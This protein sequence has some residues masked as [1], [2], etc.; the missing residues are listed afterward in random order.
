MPHPDTDALVER[1][2]SNEQDRKALYR[3][4]ARFFGGSL[5]RQRAGLDAHHLLG[6]VI[7]RVLKDGRLH[8]HPNPKAYLMRAITNAGIDAKRRDER[9]RRKVPQ[10]VDRTQEALLDHEIATI[11]RLAAASVL[12]DAIPRLPDRAKRVAR[13]K[14]DYPDL[15]IN[16]LATLLD[17]SRDTVRRAYKDMYADES[18]HGLV[19]PEIPTPPSSNTP[20][21][22]EHP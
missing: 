21:P 19:E 10:F 4:A 12:E 2:F 17:I 9:H 7:E 18:L 5:N 22:E 20:H 1:I 6:V 8:Q 14:I 3:R 11:D 16:E 13:A 15:N